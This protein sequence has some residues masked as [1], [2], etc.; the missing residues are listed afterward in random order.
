MF[1]RVVKD[2]KGSK[3][4]FHRSIAVSRFAGKNA[5]KKFNRK[6]SDYFFPKPKDPKPLAEG[7]K[8]KASELNKTPEGTD[9]AL[10][11]LVWQAGEARGDSGT[12]GPVKAS[13][14]EEYL[15]QCKENQEGLNELT[16]ALF[17]IKTERYCS[18]A[19]KTKRG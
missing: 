4:M 6:P 2:L 3:Q 1:Y 10:G 12:K 11:E 9:E 7:R 16:R 15:Q 14:C 17:D 19:K 5:P 13:I 18:S 8:R